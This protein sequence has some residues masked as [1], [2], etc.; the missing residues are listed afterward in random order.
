[1]TIARIYSPPSDDESSRHLM[2]ENGL[3]LNIPVEPRG[4][5][6]WRRRKLDKGAEPDTCFYVTNANRIIGK[7][8]LDLKSDPPPDVI[9]EID[10]TNESLNKFPIYAAFGVPEIWRYDG[11]HVHMYELRHD[12]KYLD[13]SH[14]R[15]FSTLTATILAEALESSKTLGHTEALKAFRHQLRSKKS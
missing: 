4:S 11:T 7:R 1:M 10:A 15:F 5:T 6:T 13:I 2:P 3:K 8:K 9:V 14:S 12:L